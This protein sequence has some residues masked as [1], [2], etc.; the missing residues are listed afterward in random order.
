M[1]PWGSTPQ[2]NYAVNMRAPISN[3]HPSVFPIGILMTAARPREIHPIRRDQVKRRRPGT[4][5]ACSQTG[6]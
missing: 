2:C 5:T 4:R 1:I 6:A 3:V